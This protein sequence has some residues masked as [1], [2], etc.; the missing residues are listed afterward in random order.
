MCDEERDRSPPL[1]RSSRCAPDKCRQMD[2]DDDDHQA[3][4]E[5]CS[6]AS[7]SQQ[8]T[9]RSKSLSSAI[10]DYYTR[11]G[12]NRDLEKYLRFRKYTSTGGGGGASCQR[13]SSDDS[14][15]LQQQLRQLS[16]E[17][18][19]SSSQSLNRSA[20]RS[21]HSSDTMKAAVPTT[22][23]QSARGGNSSSTSHSAEMLYVAK[24]TPKRSVHTKV[25]KSESASR[26][27]N[28]LTTTTMASDGKDTATSKDRKKVR[29]TKSSSSLTSRSLYSLTSNIEINISNLD[30]LLPKERPPP[31]SPAPLLPP[32][33]A[34]HST[35]TQSITAFDDGV[36][37]G[38]AVSFATRD[39]VA[40][41]DAV[42]GTTATDADALHEKQPADMSLSLC[43]GRPSS[44]DS[45][46]VST[47]TGGGTKPRLEW[48]SLAD[49]GY[50]KASQTDAPDGGGGGGAFPDGAGAAA[51]ASGAAYSDGSLSAFER[52]ALQKFFAERGV[53]F[54]GRNLLASLDDPKLAESTEKRTEQVEDE[55]HEDDEVVGDEE[56]Q[57]I[58]EECS[59]DGK[60]CEPVA[61]RFSYQKYMSII[62][63]C[64]FLQCN[65]QNNHPTGRICRPLQ[66]SVDS[67]P[68]L[69]PHPRQ[70]PRFRGV[71]NRVTS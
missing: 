35:Q 14:S 60:E 56:E 29:A 15:T 4:N 23:S 45:S 51:T 10:L 13:S 71:P 65:L 41:V 63:V 7:A 2:E 1:N 5:P 34:E 40:E 36:V 50:E 61:L 11:Y 49:V 42:P 46:V 31:A 18:F 48:D 17:Q 54:D 30:A 24:L 21:S 12:Q 32:R 66:Q 26:S 55:K 38:K 20:S 68:P 37:V 52:E 8:P 67:L 58:V 22:G 57:T 43:A 19:V 3:N 64:S 28:D 33:V 44:A 27:E 59:S 70:F 69:M 47:A 25:S 16:Q 39:L 62:I 9:K 6:G 53:P